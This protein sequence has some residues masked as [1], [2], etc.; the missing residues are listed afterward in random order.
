MLK[1][2]FIG[3]MVFNIAFSADIQPNEDVQVNNDECDVLYDKCIVQCDEK[4]TENTACY[5]NC[6]AI[7]EECLINKEKKE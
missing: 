3:C 2:I 1:Y 4:E 7:Y 6:E 5:S